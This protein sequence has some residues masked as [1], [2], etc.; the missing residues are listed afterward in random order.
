VTTALLVGLVS[1]GIVL[2]LQGY[3]ILKGRRKG[4]AVFFERPLLEALAL[5]D[6]TRMALVLGRLRMVYGLFLVL[7]GVWGLSGA[8]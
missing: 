2:A 7:V 3:L 1:A 5:K 4:R 8:R 6:A